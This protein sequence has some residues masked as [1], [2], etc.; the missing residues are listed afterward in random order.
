MIKRLLLALALLTLP[1][2][3]LPAASVSAVDVLDPG[4]CE[5]YQ[6]KA[7]SDKPA[8]CQ[9]NKTAQN[10]NPL[11]GK[12]G[13]LTKIVAVLSIIVGIVAIIAIL[14]AGLKYITSGSNP[15][16]VAQAREQIIYAVVALIVAA[17]AQ[18]LVRFILGKVNT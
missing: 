3:A 15:Q 7:N 9:D 16:D 6:G 13:L 4:V 18:V 1:L 10:S 2:T 12:G 14:L 17:L 11:F 8:V 5:R